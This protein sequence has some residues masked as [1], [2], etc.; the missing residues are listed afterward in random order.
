MPNG[1]EYALS[2]VEAKTPAAIKEV[3]AEGVETKAQRDFLVASGCQVFQGYFFG[4][5]MSGDDLTMRLKSGE[6][7]PARRQESI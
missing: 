3:L 4:K 7:S 5:P 2:L 1:N 6:L